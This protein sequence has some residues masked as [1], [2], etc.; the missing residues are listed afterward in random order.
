MEYHENKKAERS[1]SDNVRKFLREKGYTPKPLA[2]S[3]NISVSIAR[4]IINGKNELYALDVLTLCNFLNVSS[5]LLTGYRPDMQREGALIIE[6]KN[7]IQELV[8][9]YDGLSA[10]SK[11]RAKKALRLIS[12]GATFS[13][14]IEADKREQ[15]T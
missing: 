13:E 14:I 15:I 3:L 5:D 6:G 8:E 9:L 4:Q 2:E 11:E 12:R 1:P 10:S 7:N